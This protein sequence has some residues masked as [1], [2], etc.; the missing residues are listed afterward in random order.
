MNTPLHRTSFQPVGPLHPVQGQ[1]PGHGQPAGGQA[2][3]GEPAGRL[4]DAVFLLGRPG[5]RPGQNPVRGQRPAARSSPRSRPS[6]DDGNGL[7]SDLGGDERRQMMLSHSLQLDSGKEGSDDD[8]AG[9]DDARSQLRRSCSMSQLDRL[10][11]VEA[12]V[13]SS[14]VDWAAGVLAKGGDQALKKALVFR[15]I[16][17]AHRPEPGP[18]PPLVQRVALRAA[19]AQVAPHLRIANE[20]LRRLMIE[21]MAEL[22]KE[23]DL[24]ATGLPEEAVLANL[25]MWLFLH[26]QSLPRPPSRLNDMQDRS[27]MT[28]RACSPPSGA[29]ASVQPRAAAA[30]A[31][32]TASGKPAAKE[33]SHGV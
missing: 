8:E 14:M 1:Q 33:R 22:R 16:R 13:R 19:V 10:T 7:E 28:G 32:K 11:Q 31:D 12:A 9:S 23:L 6:Q 20:E 15:G 30:A 17:L 5:Q 18:A 3:A 21:A 29:Q 4:G 2:R 25:G 26:Q 27:A 24:P